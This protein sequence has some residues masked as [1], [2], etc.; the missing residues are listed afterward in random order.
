MMYTEK[1]K[2]GR[3]Q[4]IFEPGDWL[5][6]HFRNERFSKQ[7]K[8]NLDPRGDS[9]FQVLERICTNSYRID[10]LGDYYV[11]TTFNISYL[12]PFYVLDSRT[13]PFKE[14]GDDANMGDKHVSNGMDVNITLPPGPI[15]REATKKIKASLQHLMKQVVRE[16]MNAYEEKAKFVT[17]ENPIDKVSMNMIEVKE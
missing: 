10:L 6:V 11:Y 3:H 15:A 2:R 1:A 4:A 9:P 12:F 7:W 17:N 5:W 8:S 16:G 14:G 13:N